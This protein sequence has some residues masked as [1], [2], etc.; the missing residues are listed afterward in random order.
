MVKSLFRRLSF[1]QARN[2]V[3]IA[4]GLSLVV[5]TFDLLYDAFRRREELVNTAT[6]MAGAVRSAAAVAAYELDSKL[7]DEVISGLFVFDPIVAASVSDDFGRVLATRERVIT[8]SIPRWLATRLFGEPLQLELPLIADGPARRPRPFHSGTMRITVDPMPVAESFLT[9]LG[10]LTLG[11]LLSNLVFGM[12]LTLMFQRMVTRPIMLVARDLARL[13]P[14][15][16]GAFGAQRLTVPK[17]QERSEIGFLVERTNELLG[18]YRAVLKQR[19][20]IM[21]DLVTARQRAEDLSRSKSQFLATISHE[22]RT[23]LNAIIGFSQIISEDSPKHGPLAVHADFADEIHA[24]GQH[25]L[26]IIND[27]LDLSNLES[28]RMEPQPE[29]LEVRP[30]VE[31]CAR[32]IGAQVDGAGLSLSLDLDPDAPRMFADPRCVK[33]IAMHLLSNAVKFTPQGGRIVLGS[34]RMTGGVAIIVTDTGIGI[35]PSDTTRIFQPFWQAAPVLSRRHEGTGLGLTIVKTLVDLH[36][37][38][39]EVDSEPG[40]GTTMT[41]VFPDEGPGL[42]P[43]GRVAEPAAVV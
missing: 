37:G 42:L 40:S 31:S 23:P 5:T 4:V 3:L 1:R 43:A 9:R 39:V 33:Q 18:R 13:Q 7:A 17:G 2:T 10:S 8:G 26:T 15:D 12:I 35:Q 36:G 27:I 32:L 34:R 28:G 25:L 29:L 11:T 22:L 20:T 41:V 6:E 21:Q 24:S 30:L 14:E 16:S 19:D 38:G